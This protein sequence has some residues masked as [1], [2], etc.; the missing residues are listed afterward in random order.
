[1]HI[2]GHSIFN[3]LHIFG[4]SIFNILHIFGQLIAKGTS[5]HG[6]ADASDA[7]NYR[8]AP[9][10][11]FLILQYKEPCCDQFVMT[12]SHPGRHGQRSFDELLLQVVKYIVLPNMRKGKRILGRDVSDFRTRTDRREQFC[13]SL[14]RFAYFDQNIVSP[15]GIFLLFFTVN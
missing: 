9:G 6:S 3:I 1:M 15:V 11:Q 10:I 12:L 8:F 4:H 14:V 2:F 13:Q 5:T 7:L